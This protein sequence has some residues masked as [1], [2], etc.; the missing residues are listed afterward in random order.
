MFI[1]S[2]RL[3]KQARS[4]LITLKRYTGIKNWNTLCRWGFCASLA[5]ESIPPN[6]TIPADS[7]VEMTWKIF[8]GELSETFVALLKQRCQKDDLPIDNASLANQ[9]RLHLHR[10][11]AYLAGEREIR[12]IADLIAYGRDRYLG[13]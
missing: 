5:D 10:G 12:S 9:F 4:Q 6:M 11:I 2:I 3:S 13:S 7:T 1:E 8:A